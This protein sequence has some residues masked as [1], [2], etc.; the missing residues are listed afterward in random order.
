MPGVGSAG[1]TG[2]EMAACGRPDC[3][4]CWIPD[5]R[6]S[7]PVLPS[8]VG[9]G[10]IVYK[11]W[12]RTLNMTKNSDQEA[13][14]AAILYIDLPRLVRSANYLGTSLS[15]GGS[16]WCGKGTHSSDRCL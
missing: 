5:G 16:S 4:R 14:L 15:A 13:N 11:P 2:G 9:I 3:T 1:L 7:G 10:D 8:P 6:H 12:L